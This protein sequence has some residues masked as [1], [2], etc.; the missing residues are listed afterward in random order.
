MHT[1]LPVPG[2]VIWI[3]QRRWRVRR[4]SRH[5]GVVRL[6]VATRHEQL[7]FLAPFDRPSTMTPSER[8]RRVRRRSALARLAHLLARSHGV[9]TLLA[10]VNAD[11]ALLPY[12]LEPALAMLQGA[13]R[14]LIADEVGLGKTIQA[15]VVIAELVRRLSSGRILIVAPAALVTQ[16]SEELLQRFRIPTRTA[17][18]DRL[19]AL[20]RAGARGEN[21]WRQNG[22]WLTS[23]DYIKQ[24]HVLDALPACAW[25]LVVFDEVHG[26]CG[27]SDR[28]VAAERLARHARQVLLLTATP[29]DGDERRFARLVDLG[30]L[31]DELTVFRRTRSD[32]SLTGSRRV[33]WHHVR[34]SAEERRVLDVLHEYERA[35]LAAAGA[36]RRNA[37]LLLLSVFRKRAV[38]TMSALAISLER[39]QA[40][41]DRA[42]DVDEPSSLQPTLGFDAAEATD[43]LSADDMTSLRTDVG[44]DPRQERA[45]LRR[46]RTMTLAARPN[47]RKVARLAALLRR[48]R[49]P[50][51]VFT[52]FRHSLDVLRRHVALIRPVA[53]L[54]G[55][56]TLQERTRELDRFR[57][58]T[59]SVLLATDVAS[60]GLN[61]QHRARWAISLE[62]PW[63]PA[64][65]EQR[66]GRIDR[67]G[68]TR[69]VHFT[70]LVADHD[71]ERTV[72]SRL[73]RRTLI[74]R[75][76]LGATVLRSVDADDVQVQ[77]S[78]IAGT[79]SEPA[80]SP[81]PVVT[82]CRRWARP[83]RTACTMLAARRRLAS[84]WQSP[85]ADHGR[86]RIARASRWRVLYVFNAPIVDASGAPVEEHVVAVRVPEA[87]SHERRELVTEAARHIAVRH[88]MPRAAR[89]GRWLQR[90]HADL[91]VRERAVADALDADTRLAEVQPG[92][93]DRRALRTF[94]AARNLAIESRSDRARSIADHD[95]PATATVGRPRLALI[96]SGT[97]FHSTTRS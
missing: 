38:S 47:E 12:Q 29:H 2:E 14:V 80:T 63:N 42:G 5:R 52:E 36:D 82:L 54:H 89:V 93:F 21:P 39:R 44:L 4:A 55:G 34:L 87:A 37:A 74:A 62:M 27:D 86:P 69:P 90:R 57:D 45:W 77:H 56:Q 72:L 73:A 16:W 60:L 48:S 20:A 65:L 1:L 28:H 75:Q 40:W 8:P 41:L 58:G 68:Q 81:D 85:E 78:V 49:D 64:R 25:D 35:V 83:A 96:L 92:L 71:A 67:I 19:D 46:L 6:D 79:V 95:R 59:A 9:R 76:T 30:R 11:V 88:L 91:A 7:T 70:L 43:D 13:R 23:L 17:D 61:L 94:E 51:V 53:V 24:R 3:R 22:V 32:V 26:V 66:L 15:G 31:D 18:R 33:R 84:A 97:G 50:A 10:V